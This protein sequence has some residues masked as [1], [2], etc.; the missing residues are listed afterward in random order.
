MN[1]KNENIILENI[2]CRRNF[3]DWERDY[4]SR[5][6]FGIIMVRGVWINTWID[7]VIYLLFIYYNNPLV[8]ASK[9]IHMERSIFL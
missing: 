1:V 3:I 4:E 5:E 2:M 7:R 8:Y 6:I 9:L